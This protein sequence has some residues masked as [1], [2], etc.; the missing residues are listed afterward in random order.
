M[1]FV[2]C[3]RLGPAPP[4]PNRLQRSWARFMANGH[5]RDLKG[6]RMVAS[7]TEY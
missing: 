6:Q 2:L 3:T 7:L 4:H 1:H 5:C